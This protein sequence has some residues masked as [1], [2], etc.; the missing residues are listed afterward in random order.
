MLSVS[1]IISCTTL[2]NCQFRQELKDIQFNKLILTVTGSHYTVDMRTVSSAQ[3]HAF[4]IR[5]K[6]PSFSAYVNAKHGLR[7][8]GYS[9]PVKKKFS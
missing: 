7:H 1:A 2:D 5:H 4:L 8:V 3:K 9:K 6:T